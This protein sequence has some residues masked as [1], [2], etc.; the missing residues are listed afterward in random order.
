MNIIKRDGSIQEFNFLKIV[1]A[2]T[3][4]FNSV[5]QSVPDKFLEQLK[6]SVDKV[7]CLKGLTRQGALTIISEIG[8]FSRFNTTNELLITDNR[9]VASKILY[10]RN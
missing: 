4:A 1:D 8:D 2:V 5:E 9:N 10:K 7:S 6:E 3:K